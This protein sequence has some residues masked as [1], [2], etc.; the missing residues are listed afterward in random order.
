MA[1]KL[2]LTW[3]IAPDHE[4]EY[5][6]FVINEFVP[7]IQRLGLT[8]AEAWVTVFGEYPQIQVSIL[9]RDLLAARNAMSSEG[10]SALQDKLQPLVRNYSTKIIQARTGFQF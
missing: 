5:Y 7:G 4:Q 2:L 9:A 6:E 1:V 3:D 8:P 10:W